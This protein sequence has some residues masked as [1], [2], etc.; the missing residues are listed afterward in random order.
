MIQ[1][2]FI[3]FHQIQK[4]KDGA[5]QNILKN[6]SVKITSLNK[7]LALRRLSAARVPQNTSRAYALCGVLL[8]HILPAL[9]LLR[10]PLFGLTKR[11]LPRTLCEIGAKWRN[12]SF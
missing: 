11:Q 6:V 9:V 2:G 8:H 1:H 10:K 4:L 3:A 12:A 5:F 7:R